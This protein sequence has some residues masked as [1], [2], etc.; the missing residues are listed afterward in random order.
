MKKISQP[1][2]NQVTV[3]YTELFLKVQMQNK[4]EF[5]SENQST[6]RT[7]MQ[8]KLKVSSTKKELKKSILVK[9]VQCSLLL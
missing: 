2:K 3:K 7:Q 6:S 5:P 8:T 1:K 4:V 9:A